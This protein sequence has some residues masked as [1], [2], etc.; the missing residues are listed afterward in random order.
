MTGETGQLMDHAGPVWNGQT[1]C[2]QPFQRAQP[3][4]SL[5]VPTGDLPP[6]T[7]APGE[8]IQCLSE[9]MGK[10]EGHFSPVGVGLG[11]E[12]GAGLQ[13]GVRVLREVRH[14]GQLVHVRVNHVLRLD[15]L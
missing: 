6:E 5:H 11:A 1:A 15:Q 12:R 7:S 13:F 10:T 4:G 2:Q 3:A 9:S 8:T 14:H